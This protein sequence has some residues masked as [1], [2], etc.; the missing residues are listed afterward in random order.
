[1]YRLQA[2]FTEYSLQ[3][4]RQQGPFVRDKAGDA[5]TDAVGD[6]HQQAGEV[7]YVRFQ[8]YDV[9]A[10]AEDPDELPQILFQP[11]LPDQVVQHRRADNVVKGTVRERQFPGIGQNR[12]VPPGAEGGQG[13]RRYVNAGYVPGEP[14]EMVGVRPGT[15]PN[16]QHRIACFTACCFQRLRQRL[17]DKPV[18][19]KVSFSSDLPSPGMTG[20]MS[21]LL[22]R[23][24]RIVRHLRRL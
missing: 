15:A 11:A 17:M 22:F 10:R 23:L 9:P 20:L 24:D 18:R 7:Q 14:A 16:V 8:R 1:M 4:K 21:P 12:S 5:G 13:I 2:S 3:V 19:E 6:V